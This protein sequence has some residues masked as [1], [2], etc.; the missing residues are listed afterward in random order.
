MTEKLQY[1]AEEMD[2]KD[3]KKEDEINIE[4]QEIINSENVMNLLSK[5]PQNMKQ[6]SIVK[7][8]DE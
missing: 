7:N 5:K 6:N 3:N 8:G 1:L 4:E 2:S